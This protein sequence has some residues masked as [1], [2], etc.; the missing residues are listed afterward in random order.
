M[1]GPPQQQQSVASSASLPQLP[2][3]L[4]SLVY[5]TDGQEFLSVPL[6]VP[7]GLVVDPSSARTQWW[8]VIAAVGRPALDEAVP[9]GMPVARAEAPAISPAIAAVASKTLRCDF[10]AKFLI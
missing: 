6:P 3:E 7:A 9:A 4:E 10:I 1:P 8:P 5:R 2:V